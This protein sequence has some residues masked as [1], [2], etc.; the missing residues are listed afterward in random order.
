MQHE[1][2]GL[3][4]DSAKGLKMGARVKELP[5]PASPVWESPKAGS[6]RT[7]L[8]LGLGS[9]LHR[10][11]LTLHYPNT[12]RG[13]CFTARAQSLSTAYYLDRRNPHYSTWCTPARAV[14]TELAAHSRASREEIFNHHGGP[15][16]QPGKGLDR[17]EGTTGGQRGVFERRTSLRRPRLSRSDTHKRGLKY[18]LTLLA[19]Y[20]AT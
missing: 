20:L 12:R 19:A 15:R 1:C 14:D 10:Q 9:W 5:C 4:G 6:R 7:A 16:S 11:R 17:R 3:K 13:Y 8:V 18:I 2:R